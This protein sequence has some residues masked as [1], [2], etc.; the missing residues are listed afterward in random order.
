[1]KHVEMFHGAVTRLLT[2]QG[3]DSKLVLDACNAWRG[4]IKASESEVTSEVKLAGRVNKSG[5]DKRVLNLTDKETTKAKKAGYTAP[6]ALLAL[7]DEL[8]RVT[9]RHG[10]TIELTEFPV[11]I[12]DWLARDTFKAKVAEQ[13][14]A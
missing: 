4:S 2:K 9:E 3:L 7:S 12:V 13:Q 14:P 11:D 1:M 8:K 6:G 10:A 5:D